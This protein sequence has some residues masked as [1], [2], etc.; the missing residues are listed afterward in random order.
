MKNVYFSHI[1]I[2][3]QIPNNMF[4]D[5]DVLGVWSPA[6]HR[7]QEG[8]GKVY[9]MEKRNRWLHESH[10]ARARSLPGHRRP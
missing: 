7:L 8:D 6:V 1:P 10:Q 3:L 2:P 4:A 5:G 9:D